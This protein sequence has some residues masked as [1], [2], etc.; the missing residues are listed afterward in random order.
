VINLTYIAGQAQI[1]LNHPNEALSSALTAYELCSRSPSLTTSAF[2][3]AAFVRRCKLAKW[4]LR[5]RDRLRQRSQLLDDIVSSL[6]RTRNQEMQEL[7][8][9][10]ESGGMGSVGLREELDELKYAW[11]NKINEVRN[12][13]AIAD[14]KHL[15]KRVKLS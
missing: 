10:A 8:A 3:I 4:T 9:S 11:E 6:E 7:M 1:E 12:I 14:P 5:E 13:F 2:P 15:E